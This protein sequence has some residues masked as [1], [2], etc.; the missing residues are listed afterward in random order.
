MLMVSLFTLIGPFLALMFVVALV[1]YV[2]NCSSCLFGVFGC[3][4]R[5]AR[6]VFVRVLVVCVVVCV[7]FLFFW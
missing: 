4:V 1:V 7:V 3:L 6:G 5:E 2:I